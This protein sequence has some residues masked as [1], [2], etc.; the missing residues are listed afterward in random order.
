MRSKRQGTLSKPWFRI[1]LTG[2]M[3]MAASTFG[4]GRSSS[5]D[6]AAGLE[7]YDAGDLQAAHDTW[8]VLARDDDVQAQVALAGLLASGGPG[9]SQ[10]L[11]AA[12][13]W[14]Q[15]AAAAGDPV[16]QM[17]LG[18]FY[19]RG[20]GV[21]RDRRRA[22][23]WFSLAAEQGRQWAADEGDKLA[24]LMAPADVKAARILAE[25]LRAAP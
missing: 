12:V 1:L 10:D 2:F 11:A 18:E 17:N 3:I 21:A 6:F 14:Y 7:A 20:R 23:A 15:R 8:L 16:A 4:S 19:A 22:L 24:A 9:L 25:A 5:E 13:L